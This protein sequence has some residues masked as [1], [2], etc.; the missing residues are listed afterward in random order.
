MIWFKKIL[1]KNLYIL[2][3]YLQKKKLLTITTDYYVLQRKTAAKVFS[4]H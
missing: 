1:N 2:V 4:N 3:K